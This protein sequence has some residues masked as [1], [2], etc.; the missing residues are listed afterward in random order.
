M[1]EV[2]IKTS[3]L[4]KLVSKHFKTD[5]IS[6]YDLTRCI[7]DLTFEIERLEEK[8]QDINENVKENY[9]SKWINHYEQE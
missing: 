4:N 6:V 1:K 7:E 8:I 5:L 9:K 2:Y 3:D